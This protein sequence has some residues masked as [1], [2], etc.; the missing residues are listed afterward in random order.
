M[1]EKSIYARAKPESVQL[2]E[3]YFYSNEISRNRSVKAEP[4]PNGRIKIEV[5]FD[6]YQYFTFQAYKDVEEQLDKNDTK[7]ATNAL[8]GY[9]SFANYKR[10][11]LD[12]RL[13]LN[14]HYGSVPI[15]VPIKG[16]ELVSIESLR[17]DRHSCIISY[18]Y[19]PS[20]PKTVPVNIV[21]ELLDT[22]TLL[23]ELSTGQDINALENIEAQIVQQ[24]NFKPNLLLLMSVV[25]NIPLEGELNN[26]QPRIKRMSLRWPTITSLHS[27][28]ISS[29]SKQPIPVKYN[30]LTRSLEWHNILM[31]ES[32]ESQSGDRKIYASEIMALS[33]DQP[34]ELYQQ[35]AL[36]G[37]I[38]IE[39]P[40]YLLSGLQARLYG[41]TGT[42]IKKTEP[43][44]TTEIITSFNMIL[45]DAFAR[46]SRSTRQHLYFDG[47]IPEERRVQD[48]KQ[49]LVD[50][51][52]N[53]IQENYPKNQG[54]DKF[55][56]LLHAEYQEGSDIMELKIIIEGKQYETERQTGESSDQTFKTKLDCGDIKVSIRG[57]KR[58]DVKTLIEKMNALQAMLRE[59]F[60]YL[61]VKR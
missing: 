26:L 20:F 10:T 61:K 38:E 18:D 31:V 56:R 6:G 40:Q 34:G 43:K 1:V 21:M 41:A 50:L 16:N 52:F 2:T 3:T 13:A 55:K 49:A 15:Q 14:S 54:R 48:I 58:G 11:D 25:L 39:I 7:V 46:R 59:R 32:Q 42:L 53:K 4:S 30:P 35:N 60:V 9:L 29:S 36:E 17:D 22:E 24:I 33:I 45:D 5:P 37:Q 27:L 23:T 51:G 28:Q 47:I 57:E 19:S 44:L 12:Q 8:I